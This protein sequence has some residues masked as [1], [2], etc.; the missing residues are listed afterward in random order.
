[1]RKYLNN[2]WIVTALALVAIAFVWASLR[3]TTV[4]RTPRVAAVSEN[5][6]DEG[7][8]AESSSAELAPTSI[9]E[10]LKAI[11]LTAVP[12]DP[13]AGRPKVSVAGLV[14]QP[15]VPDLV[16]TIK[17][18]AIWTQEGRTYVLINGRIHQVGDEISRMT[19]ESATQ[20]GVWVAHW[21]GRDFLSV[22][23]H[24]TLITPGRKP[25]RAA[26]L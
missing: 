3:P 18:S 14:A 17:L 9:E 25:M 4:V 19:I 20:E 5:V 11:A 15:A 16:D 6:A 2:P 21:K 22:G 7:I 13:F 10:A 12:R 23:T 8:S 1:M 24:F 26:A